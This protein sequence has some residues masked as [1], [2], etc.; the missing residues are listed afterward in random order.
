MSIGNKISTLQILCM[1]SIFIFI[2]GILIYISKLLTSKMLVEN[3]HEGIIFNFPKKIIHFMMIT[4]GGIV[5]APFISNTINDIYFD[6]TLGIYKLVFIR[7][8]L[9]MVISI[10]VFYICSNFKKVKKDVYY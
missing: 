3:M 2:G 8:I 10:I 6:N 4:F 5:F 1:S 9:I 7:V